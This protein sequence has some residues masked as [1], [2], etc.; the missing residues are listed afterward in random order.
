MRRAIA[1]R[2]RQLRKVLQT[3]GDALNQA[4]HAQCVESV[5]RQLDPLSHRRA[6]EAPLAAD[7]TIGA[8]ERARAG[9]R[10]D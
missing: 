3:G 8:I 2:K 10:A 6:R 4:E 9:A 5:E 7:V 1:E